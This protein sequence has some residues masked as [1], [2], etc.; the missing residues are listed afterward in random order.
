[1]KRELAVEDVVS[2]MDRDVKQKIAT[3]QLSVED[4]ADPMEE[5]RNVK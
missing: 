5:G 2:V 3:K 4:A 1:M